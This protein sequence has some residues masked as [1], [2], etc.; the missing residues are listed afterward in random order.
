MIEGFVL[1]LSVLV[2]G[3]WLLGAGVYIDGHIGWENLTHQHPTELAALMAG[4]F[5]P[6]A[7]LWLLAAYFRQSSAQRQLAFALKQLHWQ[8]RK[9]AEQTET[10]V[11]ALAET[12]DRER[13]AAALDIVNRGL[14]DLQALA[15]QLALSLGRLNQDD[16]PD[17]WRMT[18]AGDRFAFFRLLLGNPSDPQAAGSELAAR[19]TAVPALKPM[20]ADFIQL[21]ERLADFAAKRAID[22]L[23]REGLEQGPPA[24]LHALLLTALRNQPAAA[25]PRNP[26]AESANSS[27]AY[28]AHQVAKVLWPEGTAPPPLPPSQPANNPTT[29]AAPWPENPAVVS[30]AP[31]PAEA[32]GQ[33]P[34]SA[35]VMPFSPL[36]PGWPRNPGP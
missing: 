31:R 28:T 12:Q 14:A 25:P 21:Q 7:L 5:A 10:I 29:E 2:S 22:P 30:Q 19:L 16:M 26:L 33:T 1:L 35:N 23:L 17:L 4:I 15:A 34:A 8:A 32:E 20:I 24:K 9:S 6:L 27:A 13:Q 18:R 36:A 11:R 3:A